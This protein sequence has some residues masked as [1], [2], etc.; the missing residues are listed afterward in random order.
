[1]CS[2]RSDCA[3]YSSTVRFISEKIEKNDGEE[4][5]ILSK[6]TDIEKSTTAA[7]IMIFLWT[8]LFA[9]FFGYDKDICLLIATL[10]ISEIIFIYF[11]RECLVDN[12]NKH[13]SIREIA[14]LKAFSIMSA[15]AV[16]G[17][18]GLLIVIIYI[19]LLVVYQ[20]ITTSMPQI[21]IV[22]EISSAFVAL[23]IVN[24]LITRSIKPSKVQTSKRVKKATK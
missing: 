15:C 2:R 8:C 24:Y 18:C 9:I 3:A 4:L 22:A 17:V 14:I 20:V 5:K 16:L 7:A 11:H 12:D 6:Y 23:V 19:D 10:S 13:F 1:M 21:L